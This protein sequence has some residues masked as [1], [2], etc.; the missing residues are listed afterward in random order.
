MPNNEDKPNAFAARLG[1]QAEQQDGQDG[2]K[3]ADPQ[4]GAGNGESDGEETPTELQDVSIQEDTQ[5]NDA[6]QE[7]ARIAAEAQE[8]LAAADAAPTAI[9]TST[10]TADLDAD[11][12]IVAAVDRAPDA[13]IV[14]V[15]PEEGTAQ[16]V[17]NQT[18][19]A[20]QAQDDA[21]IYSCHPVRNL[22]IGDF[23]FENSQLRLESGSKE[24]TQFAE[25]LKKLPPIERNR[26]VR[27]DRRAAEEYLKRRF[28]SSQRAGM[29]TSE[30][31]YQS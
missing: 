19:E 9:H 18:Q 23:R 17:E 29:D 30:N 21:I 15:H 6:Q 1:K 27:V 16:F 25:L 5:S 10:D 4:T 22:K 31:S 20:T 13:D 7:Q 11:I 26:I 28:G 12:G 14:M 8:V 24:A 3:P 2:A